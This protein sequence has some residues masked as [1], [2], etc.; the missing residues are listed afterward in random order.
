MNIWQSAA[1]MVTVKVVSA[2]PAALLQ[3][4]GAHGIVLHGIDMTD[5][6]TLR[7]RLLRRDW[8]SLGVLC[9]KRGD[10]A[11]ILGKEG[12]FWSGKALLGRPVLILGLLFWMAMSLWLPSRVL[13]VEVEGNT[14]IPAQKIL[15]AA[16]SCGIRFGASR[17][18]VR[19][20]KMKNALL[21]S[22]E[23]LKW[24]GVNTYGCRAVISVREKDECQEP[25]TPSV[26]SVV[27][28]RDG[29][30]TSCTVTGGSGQCQPGQTVKAGQL[31]IS[32]YT[33]CGIAIR[34]EKAQ[35]EIYADTRREILAVTPSKAA[36]RLEK[37]EESRHI[38]ILIGKKRIN[39][40]KGSGIWDASCG[41]M[42]KE[43]CITLPGGFALPLGV[44][45]ER[46]TRWETGMGE[47]PEDSVRQDLIRF[48]RDQ[49][50]G[51]MIAGRVLS[52]QHTMTR[53]PGRYVLKADFLCNEMI[54]R[55]YALKIGETNE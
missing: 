47:T 5:P 6:L 39:F 19:S 29:Y 49:V 45:V 26:T 44:A 53:E 51:Q 48:A 42:Y 32:P 16:Q 52:L 2:D 25:E 50:G 37:G 9:Q 14:Q 12:I 15:E 35:G 55:E 24:A 13:F 30:I 41:R 46:V 3:A 10:K 18:A 23:E 38:S 54:G 34:V 1:G 7:F 4:A 31:L 17:R 33:D 8:K 28:V 11:E 43:Y 27:A 21:S 22:L 36:V 40:W 20:E